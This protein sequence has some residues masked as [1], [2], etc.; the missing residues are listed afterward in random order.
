[1]MKRHEIQVLLRARLPQA[2]VARIAG[3]SERTVRSVQAETPVTGVDLSVN[4]ED[5]KPFI[6]TKTADE[7]LRSVANF[8]NRISGS[9]H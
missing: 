7:I 9:G 5:P 2:E 8:R 4:N 3:V 1:M 6:W